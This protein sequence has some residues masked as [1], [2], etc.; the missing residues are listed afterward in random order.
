MSNSGEYEL[1]YRT[2]DGRLVTGWYKLHDGMDHG[3]KQGRADKDN[4]GRG[5]CRNGGSPSEAHARR[6]RSPDC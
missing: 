5:L 3:A 4:A 2:A 6:A 1:S